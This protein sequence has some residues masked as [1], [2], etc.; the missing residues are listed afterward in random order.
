MGSSG[1]NYLNLLITFSVSHGGTPWPY[2]SPDTIQCKGDKFASEMFLPNKCS[3][4]P[5]QISR[6]NFQEKRKEQDR[7]TMRE[8][9]DESQLAWPPQREN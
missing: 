6:L 1:A 2:V 9:S 3:L 4:S 5:P 7:G 8:Q